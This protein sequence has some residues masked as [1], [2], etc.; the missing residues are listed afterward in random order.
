MDFSFVM[1]ITGRLL[2][3][4]TSGLWSAVS[5]SL[6]AKLHHASAYHPQSLAKH[7]HC[8]LKSSLHSSISCMIRATAVGHAQITHTRSSSVLLLNWSAST[9]FFLASISA[10]CLTYHLQLPQLVIICY[11]TLLFPKQPWYWWPV[12]NPLLI[13]TGISYSPHLTCKNL[14]VIFTDC[15]ASPTHHLLPI[16][17]ERCP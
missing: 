17:M 16:Y 4:F 9:P 7:L 8:G 14:R 1:I 5:S 2:Y 15:S 3:Q 10:A 6:W 13:S 11:L 12:E